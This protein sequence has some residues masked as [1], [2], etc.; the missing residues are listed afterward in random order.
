MT[1][2]KLIDFTKSLISQHDKQEIYNKDVADELLKWYKTNCT[3]NQDTQNYVCSY[4]LNE[5]EVSII[6]AT[7]AY[8]ARFCDCHDI[9]KVIKKLLAIYESPIKR[10]MFY[11]RHKLDNSFYQRLKMFY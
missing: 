6:I 1:D 10:N 8:A 5:I 11:I 4:D 3:I 9:T 7:E 2:V